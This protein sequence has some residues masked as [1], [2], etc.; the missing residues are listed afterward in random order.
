VRDTS[1]T[2]ELGLEKIAIDLT[3][4]PVDN[5]R[6]M[7]TETKRQT[8]LSPIVREESNKFLTFVLDVNPLDKPKVDKAIKLKTNSVEVIFNP[9][10]IVRLQ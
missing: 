9:L 2:I 3:T 1:S 7:V 8:F 6:I 10:L 5:G 4:E